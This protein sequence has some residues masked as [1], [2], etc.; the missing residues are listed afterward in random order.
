[1]RLRSWFPVVALLAGFA[2]GPV[3]AGDRSLVIIFGPTGEKPGS[4]A[5]HSAAGTLRN[6]LRMDG[7]AVELR[8]PGAPDGQQLTRNMP[9]NPTFAFLNDKRTSSEAPVLLNRERH[10]L[11]GRNYAT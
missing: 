3:H 9:P 1:M 2:A 4:L 6:W 10:F 5:V 8:R 7:A 11:A